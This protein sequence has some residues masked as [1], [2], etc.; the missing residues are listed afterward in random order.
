MTVLGGALIVWALLSVFARARRAVPMLPEPAPSVRVPPYVLW[1]P[2]DAPTP[3]L[4]PAPARVHFGQEAPQEANFVLRLGVGVTATND[5]PRRLAACGC[6]FVSVFPA[7]RGSLDGLSIERWRRGFSG[8]SRVRDPRRPEAFADERCVFFRLEDLKLQGPDGPLALR[9]ARA[10]KAHALAVD[11]RDAAGPGFGGGRP[12]VEADALTGSAHRQDLGAM[13]GQDLVLQNL[14]GGAPFVA[15]VLVAAGLLDDDSRPAALVALV[16]GAL[17]R[18]YTATT[19]GFGFGLAILG[20]WFSWARALEVLRCERQP[21]RAFPSLP[22]VPPPRATASRSDTQLGG[23]LDRAA[24]PFLARRL[25]GSAIVMEHI[26]ASVPTG[27]GAFGRFIDALCLSSASSRAVRHR[28]W[29]TI[30]L[31]RGLEPHSLLSVPSGGAVDAAFIMAPELVLVDPDASARALAKRRCPLATVVTG[32]VDS[33]PA[34]PF[35]VC[36][37]IGLAEYFDDAEV[38][39]QLIQLR[40]RLKPQGAIVTSTTDAHPDQVFMRQRLGWST[41][42][43]RPDVY[44]A[45]LDAA[46]FRVEVRESDPQGIQWVF[47]ARPRGQTAA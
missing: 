31:T 5:L 47:V 43:R 18:L 4:E 10:R 20:P 38:V 3:V 39:R 21:A 42:T 13:T 36:L 12:L 32:T 9:V 15:T 40:A 27:R 26:Y 7:P 14:I 2:Q 35:D 1:L 17:G 22:E 34:G 8:A 11:L 46:G 37:Y 23:A 16:L 45:L 29:S 44:A 41:R 33:A 30:A 6:D 24:L 25:G 19:E 28:L